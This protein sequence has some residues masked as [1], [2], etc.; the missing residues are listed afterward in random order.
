MHLYKLVGGNLFS[1]GYKIIFL[2]L[3]CCNLPFHIF[4]QNIS[5]KQSNHLSLLFVGDVMGHSDQIKSAELVKD[6]H[7]DY[8]PNF[9]YIKPIIESADLAVANLELTLPG[10]PPYTG[11]PIFRSPNELASALRDT[12][13][14]VVVTANNHSNDG[15][16]SALVNTISTL[17][18]KGF[19]QTG[20]FRNQQEKELHYPLI[21]Y[22]NGFKLAFL[23]Y[24]FSTNQIKTKYPTVVNDLDLELIIKDMEIANA[25]DPDIII[26]LLHW[27]YEY[28]IEENEKQEQ[29][30][31]K[32][33]KMG[34]DLIIGSHPHVVQPIKE[35]T[36]IKDNGQNQKTIV[37]YSL[38]NFISNQ[39]RKNTDGGIIF[40]V[41][42]E[43]E[44]NHS[45]VILSKHH[46]IPIWRYIDIVNKRKKYYLLPI[47]AFEDDI[48][49]K[50]DM[51]LKS[52][53]AMN[54]YGKNIRNHLKNFDST[55]KKILLN[56]IPH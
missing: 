7:Y 10:H 54:F 31:E 36:T 51:S 33:S 53:S 55:E 23:N 16:K 11:Y 30:A 29:I 40:E 15:G 8:R 18:E 2:S 20:T 4:G 17:E 56:D 28:K 46:Y 45:E 21:V 26:V 24:T 43:K 9:K 22:K 41:E 48:D 3:L 27:G 19:Y 39:N 44:D 49:N 13:F 34:A 35:I 42:F 37:A 38:G 47:S 14:D 32:L 1:F 52:R 50:I 12:G 6:L 5:I 25:I